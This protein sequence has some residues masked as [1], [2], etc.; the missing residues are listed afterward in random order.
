MSDLTPHKHEFVD[1][2]SCRIQRCKI[3]AV[4]LDVVVLNRATEA[5]AEVSRLRSRLTA[6]ASE[7]VALQDER[8]RL[9]SIV[10]GFCQ[11]LAC[12]DPENRE[13]AEA[14]AEKIVAGAAEQF[15]QLEA[16]KSETADLKQELR[17]REGLS[18]KLSQAQAELAEAKAQRS[19]HETGSIRNAGRAEAAEAA[20]ANMELQAAKNFELFQA[21]HKLRFEAEAALASM[22]AENERA[23]AVV[24]A[25]EKLALPINGHT[26]DCGNRD[27]ATSKHSP[28][29]AKCEEVRKSIKALSSPASPEA[30]KDKPKEHMCCSCFTQDGKECCHCRDAAKG[31]DQA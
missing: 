15:R 22:K 19:I 18:V 25:L 9:Q 14:F 24:E 23:R 11:I 31:G 3:C 4:P 2:P 27:H 17:R 28:S 7:S 16:A 26:S 20:L 29:V 13:Q 12:P 5:E 10:N 8:S 30:A 1:G 6:A 21:E